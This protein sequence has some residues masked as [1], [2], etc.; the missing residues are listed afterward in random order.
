MKF[1][2]KVNW[3]KILDILG[4]IGF[5]YVVIYAFLKLFGVLHSPLLADGAAIAGVAFAAG[6]LVKKV[7]FMEL[8]LHRHSRELD[9]IKRELAMQDHK[10][11]MQDNTRVSQD[12]KLEA[13]RR[14]FKAHS[15]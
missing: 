13:I 10:G 7:D 12:N 1:W 3:M 5:Y 6:K 4:W 11:V 8:E 2:K 15:H 9:S 14:S